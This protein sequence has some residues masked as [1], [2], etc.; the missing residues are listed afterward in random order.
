[1]IPAG[2]TSSTKKSRVKQNHLHLRVGVIR[3]PE[4]PEFL[5]VLVLRRLEVV[6]LVGVAVVTSLL[7]T[8]IS[9]LV[10]PPLY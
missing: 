6:S 1:M 2:P 7:H 9:S 5:F 10:Y 3:P 4:P 8:N